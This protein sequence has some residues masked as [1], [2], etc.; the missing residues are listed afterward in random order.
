M[1]KVSVGMRFS[2]LKVLEKS[3]PRKWKVRC[4]CGN[5]LIVRGGNLL[6]STKSCGCLKKEN[7][8]K[9]FGSIKA[10]GAS[11]R[12]AVLTDY[13]LGAIKRNLIWVLTETEF[14]LLTT[15]SCAYCGVLPSQER[16]T[17]YH[18]GSFIYN[19]I[20]RVDNARGYESSNVVPC[21]KICNRAKDIMTR[22]EF[23][24]WA[25]RVVNYNEHQI[26]SR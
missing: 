25:K 9:N 18:N 10:P 13:K 5:E 22:E 17:Q 20:D 7:S 4:D 6:R 26:Y 23:L 24:T 12:T 14:D 11:A 1:N 15:S 19:G 8:W 16:K 21:C 2:R 3:G